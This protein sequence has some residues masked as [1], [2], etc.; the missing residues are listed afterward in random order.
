MAELNSDFQAALVQAATSRNYSP[1]RA[2]LHKARRNARFTFTAD[3]SRADGDKIV[4]G[5]LA[6]PGCK[7]IPEE[8]RI[9]GTGTGT[10]AVKWT[11]QK[12]DKDGNNAVAL[13]AQTSQV[14]DPKAITTLSAPSS[15]PA[16]VALAETDVIKLVM[17]YGTGTT[18]TLAA[19]NTFEVEIG[20]EAE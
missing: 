6:L 19:T 15:A 8:T 16:P 10:T 2:P 20:Y 9:R 14:T 18:L 12:T 11:L 13:S 3:G 17:N 1:S 5:S 7:I 4:L